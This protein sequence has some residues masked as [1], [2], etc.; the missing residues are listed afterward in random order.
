VSGIRT[1]HPDASWTAAR[2]TTLKA[3]QRVA[4]CLPCRDEATTIGPLVA[5]IRAALVDEVPLVD[6]LVVLD[7]GSS[8]A[9]AA[10]AA[11]AGAR[12][13]AVADATARVGAPPGRGKGNVLWASLLATD[14]EVVIWCDA[15]LTSFEPSWIVRLVLPLLLEADVGLVKADYE[16]PADS[17]G[18]GR[19]TELMAR[20]LLSLYFPELASLVQPLGGEVAGRRSLLERV[21][22]VAGWGV[23]VGLLVDVLRLAGAEAIAQ[24]DLGVRRH[25][26]RPLGE[27]AVQAAE[28]GATILRR[29]GA[30]LGPAGSGTGS[31]P[32]L[33]RPDGRIVPLNLDE[34]PALRHAL[35]ESAQIR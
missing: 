3:G 24:V 10:V 15:D 29:A 17:G 4:V 32:A 13:V 26:H 5:Q 27:L 19:T 11:D 16:R 35:D 28:V 21:P 33:R 8:D 2:A 20:P 25:R 7:D 6:D 18:G 34:R 14:A 1:Y 23:E 31:T 22:F 9:T 30:P 12:V